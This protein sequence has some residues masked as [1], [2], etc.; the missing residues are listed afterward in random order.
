MSSI[1][2]SACASSAMPCASIS[3]RRA[4]V[5]RC[6]AG[7]RRSRKLPPPMVRRADTSRRMKRSPTAA[8]MGRSS[9][10][11]TGPDPPGCKA[12]ASG[13]IRTPTSAAPACSRAGNQV[14]IALG[15]PASTRRS[16]SIRSVGACSAGAP[17]TCPRSI[18][19]GAMP[20]PARLSAQRCPATPSPAGRFCAWMPRTRAA[21]PEGDRTT[22]SPTLTRPDCT[23]P[24][25]T[26]PVPFSEKLRSTAI[27]NRRSVPRAVVPASA[28]ASA[29]RKVSSPS[30]VTVET[31]MMSDPASAVGA[32]RSRIWL[33][34]SARRASSAR[35]ALVIATIPR[36]T[37]SR[38]RMARCSRVCGMTPSFA[39]TTSSARS[40][41][42][43]P[44]SIVWTNRSCPGTSTK[45]V[46]A[47][48]SARTPRSA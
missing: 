29:A 1:A 11:C 25:T 43:A 17:T 36:V 14:E 26:V 13:T 3:C 4:G 34:T 32:I 39:A 35:S 7:A 44:A 41:P 19:S 12:A 46:I 5:R 30:P 38:S 10:S 27:R 45:P 18:R 15:S 23:V 40:I 42:P 20:S 24:V 33:S 9:T 2:A 31:A 8:A 28:A 16:A 48:P 6:R 47:P 22:T 37:P 21:R